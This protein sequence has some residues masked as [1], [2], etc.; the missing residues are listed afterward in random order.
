MTNPPIALY[1]IYIIEHLPTYKKIE[2]LSPIF[3][4]THN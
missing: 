2:L 1:I 3:I 4:V